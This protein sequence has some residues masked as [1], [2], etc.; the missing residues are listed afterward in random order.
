MGKQILAFPTCLF[1]NDR[2]TATARF[3]P[4]KLPWNSQSGNRY[5]EHGEYVIL[6]S[7]CRWW[8]A[9]AAP[10]F[11][12][13]RMQIISNHDL[14]SLYL[15]FNSTQNSS[16]PASTEA[17]EALSLRIVHLMTRRKFPKNSGN[18]KPSRHINLV[19]ITGKIWTHSF[20]AIKVQNQDTAR[21]CKH[22][23]TETNQQYLACN[24]VRYR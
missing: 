4:W 1:R 8:K 7:Q 20:E 10:I 2:P 11:H 17:A 22:K 24:F 19:S 12:Q 6:K 13:N 16:L 21:H 18:H 3:S 5:V 9:E 15:L 23:G 14:S